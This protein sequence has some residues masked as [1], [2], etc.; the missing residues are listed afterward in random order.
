MMNATTDLGLMLYG[1]LWGTIISGSIAT[2]IFGFIRSDDLD[3]NMDV[4]ESCAQSFDR[5]RAVA[6]EKR[7]LTDR[8][9]DIDLISKASIR[10]IRARVMECSSDILGST[11]IGSESA[12][13]D[14]AVAEEGG[15]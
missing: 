8:M 12:T 6:N 15:A 7:R 4:L 13:D 14:G 2:A 10:T 3:R 11:G 1:A 5:I 9:E